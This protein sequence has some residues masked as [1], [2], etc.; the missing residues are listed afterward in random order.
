LGVTLSGTSETVLIILSKIPNYI[1][2]LKNI[3]PISPIFNQIQ[4]PCCEWIHRNDELTQNSL[5]CFANITSSDD[6]LFFM[7]S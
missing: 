4:M 5:F 3:L 1:S 7:F 2:A 6:I